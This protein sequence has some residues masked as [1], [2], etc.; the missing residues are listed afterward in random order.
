MIV[1]VAP[2]TSAAWR[3]T[4]GAIRESRSSR[5][6][7]FASDSGSLPMRV[8]A[9]CSENAAEAAAVSIRCSVC[10]AKKPGRICWIAIAEVMRPT[11]VTVTS[12]R[13]SRTF[14]RLASAGRPRGS[15]LDQ[16]A[17]IATTRAAGQSSA[18]AYPTP[19]TVRM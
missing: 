17:W 3:A 8:T 19:L 12:A 14:S 7:A 10:S 6:W 11:R 1:T 4:S 15:K 9:P 18:K 13:T 5:T 2:K 16:S